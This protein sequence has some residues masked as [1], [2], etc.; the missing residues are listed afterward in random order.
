MK[1]FLLVF[2]ADYKSIPKTSPEQMQANTQKW[3]NWIASIA[4]QNKLSDKG[5]RLEASG[6]VL[7]SGGILSDG[8]YTEI[9][10]SIMG[11]TLINA[12][13]LEEATNLCKECPILVFG[14]SVEI[15]E[16]STL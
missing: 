5:N 3:M 12:D 9:K 13:S 11:Y 2:R 1:E 4:A 16:I 15:R 8:P 10:E 6:Q 14:G 7:K